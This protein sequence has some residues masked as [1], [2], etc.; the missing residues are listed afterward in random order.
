MHA[1]WDVAAVLGGGVG[2]TDQYGWRGAQPGHALLADQAE[3]LDG[4]GLWQT[5]VSGGG[6]RHRPDE[7]PSIGVEHR[8][9]PQVP[10]ADPQAQVEQRSNDVEV[11]V[12]VGDHHAFGTRRRATRVVD[13]E[14]VA[15]GDVGPNDGG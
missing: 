9:G 12:A 14:E 5:D 2:E 10:V 4:I 1:T 7:R 11:G 15:L 8:Q 13:G 6:G 3:D